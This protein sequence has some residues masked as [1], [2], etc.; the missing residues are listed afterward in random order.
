MS[1]D[2]PVDQSVH[3]QRQIV[4]IY[5]GDA[6]RVDELGRDRYLLLIQEEARLVKEAE[7]EATDQRADGKGARVS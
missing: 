1:S 4:A 3:V 6:P 5:A 7:K 2:D